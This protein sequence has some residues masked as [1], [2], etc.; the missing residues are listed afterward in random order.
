MRAHAIAPAPRALAGAPRARGRA[1]T[2]T[3]GVVARAATATGGGDGDARAREMRPDARGRA[4]GR[5]ER[6]RGVESRRARAS[7]GRGGGGSRGGR[8]VDA[9][10]GTR[11]RGEGGRRGFERARAHG[12]EFHSCGHS[13]GKARGARA[14]DGAMSADEDEFVSQAGMMAATSSG[15][16]APRGRTERALDA[17]FN[18]TG[19]HAVADFLRGNAAVAVVSWA[20][21]SRRGGGARG[22]ARRRRRIGGDDDGGE[23]QSGVHDSGLRVGGDAR[24]CG[25]DVRARGGEREHFTCS[26]RWPWFGTVLLGVRDGGRAALGALRPGALRG[27]SIDAARSGGFEGAVGARCPRRR[28]SCSCSPMGRRI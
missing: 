9:G 18:A 4:D 21:F 10:R 7:W 1:T 3:R 14:M 2:A 8:A 27:G 15:E 26:R 23:R 22:D 12:G 28:T 19:L 5:V 17:M 11:T 24:V 20:L 25:R 6:A 13:H 16:F